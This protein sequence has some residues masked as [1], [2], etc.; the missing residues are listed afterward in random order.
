[1]THAHKLHFT[2]DY[3]FEM[4]TLHLFNA[5][6]HFVRTY[7]VLG[8]VSVWKGN[9]NSIKMDKALKQKCY[10]KK[11]PK[12]IESQFENQNCNID[13]ISMVICLNFILLTQPP[14]QCTVCINLN[15][16]FFH[17]LKSNDSQFYID[18]FTGNVFLARL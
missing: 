5:V 4:P 14:Y 15:L 1:M 7:M 12:C 9:E 2:L 6:L 8:F 3:N 10:I 13:V 18:P 16:V 11:L 17:R